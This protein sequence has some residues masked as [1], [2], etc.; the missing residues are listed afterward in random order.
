[1]VDISRRRGRPRWMAGRTDV[2][3]SIYASIS[4]TASG[5]IQM[6]EADLGWCALRYLKTRV[7]MGTTPIGNLDSF[8]ENDPAY[9]RCAA[10]HY[11]DLGE[12]AVRS[13]APAAAT[14]AKLRVPP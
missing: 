5:L 9:R 3:V 12:K 7:E 8:E 4:S 11:L 10:T 2:P 1:L 14:T 6:G 13:H